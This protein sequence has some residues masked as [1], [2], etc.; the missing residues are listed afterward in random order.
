MTEDEYQATI[1]RE[2][3]AARQYTDRLLLELRRRLWPDPAH[4][5]AA[6]ENQRNRHRAELA[7]QA[8]WGAALQRPIYGGICGA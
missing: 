8:Y 6:R 7:V 5:P 3:M 4:D 2:R 1:W